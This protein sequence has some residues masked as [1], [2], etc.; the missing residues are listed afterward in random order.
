MTL[1]IDINQE[2]AAAPLKRK[3]RWLD[4]L[5]LLLLSYSGLFRL[6]SCYRLCSAWRILVLFGVGLFDLLCSVT[7]LLFEHFCDFVENGIDVISCL[8]WDT[9][10]R[11]FV[12]LYQLLEFFLFEISVLTDNNLSKS[13]LLPQIKEI[14]L[15]FLF[16]RNRFTQSSRLLRLFIS[17]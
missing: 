4:Q 15:S 9:V 1:N 12:L 10:V 17:K 16:C 11:H 6:A 7:I 13:L 8:G 14:A 5:N 2:S 3:L